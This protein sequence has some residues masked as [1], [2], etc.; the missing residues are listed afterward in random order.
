MQPTKTNAVLWTVAIVLFSSLA[1]AEDS[2][3]PTEARLL[4]RANAYWTALEAR[5]F[6]TLYS[7]EAGARSGDITPE[8]IRN[9]VGRSRVLKYAFKGVRIEKDV[10][11]IMV[12]RVYA[13]S[14]IGGPIPVTQPDQWIFTDGDWYHALG[15]RLD[16]KI[17]EEAREEAT[18][19][20][21]STP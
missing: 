4:E 19:E 10:A 6:A 11:A 13:V 7:F 12:E 1:L 15:L 14:G 9:N 18:S 20:V 2:N 8:V 3:K 17:K 21:K 16:K 5:D